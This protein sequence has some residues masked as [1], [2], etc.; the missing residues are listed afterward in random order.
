MFT[1]GNILRLGLAVNHRV[2]GREPEALVS[3]G[4]CRKLR[5]IKE[6][7]RRTNV[8]RAFVPFVTILIALQFAFLIVLRKTN[9]EAQS[10]KNKLRA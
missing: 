2:D 9:L 3:A 8:W 5:I 6:K 4:R 7:A 1:F 10:S